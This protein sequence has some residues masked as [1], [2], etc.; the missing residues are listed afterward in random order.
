MAKK[1]EKNKPSL[2]KSEVEKPKV[3]RVVK[4]KPAQ[5]MKP[6]LVSSLFTSESVTEG[7]PDKLCDQVSDAILDEILKKDPKARVAVECLVTNGVL[8]I[9]G[10]ISTGVYVE[11]PKI[12]RNVI[13]D[14]GYTDARYGFHYQTSGIQVAIQQQSDDIQKAVDRYVQDASGEIVGEDLANLGAGDQGLVFGYA[15]D[16]TEE[17]MPMPIVL[18]HRLC[19]KLSEV[20]KKNVIPALRPDGKSQVTVEYK[21]GKVKRIHTVLVAAQ[22][23]GGVDLKVFRD[24]IQ[25]QVIEKTLPEKL[26]DKKTKFYINTS[27]NFV[28]GGPQADTGLTGRKIIVDSYGGMARHGGGCFSGKD[29]T[30]VD[31]SGA[32]MAR[33]VAKNLVAAGLVKK[34]E[35]Q[36]AY[37]IGKA[38][39]LAVN[40]ETFG[41]G[42]FTQEELVAI[43]QMVFDLRPGKIIENLELR[44]P[45]YRQVATYG[46]FGRE[47]VKVPWEKTDKIIE[48]QQAV[49]VMRKKMKK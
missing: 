48:I 15:S 21:N 11:I 31:R 17:L 38:E 34:C 24:Q 26:V 1:R 47:D 39:P 7:H 22:H 12:A 20:R 9:A 13:R 43:V 2:K 45:I 5:V 23:D 41:T 29:A 40:I 3:S 30:K 44:K 18:A 8:T 14:I 35:V 19:K 32:Y 4:V 36:I 25:K 6:A 10:E 27:G 33:Y 16:E 49:R 28:V 46:H 42:K 37:A